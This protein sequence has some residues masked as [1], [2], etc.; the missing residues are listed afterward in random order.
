MLETGPAKSKVKRLFLP[1]H[2]TLTVLAPCSLQRTRGTEQ[3]KMGVAGD[4]DLLAD[5]C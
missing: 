1:A 3:C 2:G 5:L 4:L